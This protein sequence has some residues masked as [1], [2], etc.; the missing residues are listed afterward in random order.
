MNE[1]LES[2]FDFKTTE[3]SQRNRMERDLSLLQIRQTS[4]NFPCLDS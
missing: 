2:G 1:N 4:V 3:K